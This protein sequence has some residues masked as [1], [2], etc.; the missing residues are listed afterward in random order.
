MSEKKKKNNR[1]RF[2]ALCSVRAGK[3]QGHLETYSSKGQMH[4]FC[5]NVTMCEGQGENSSL[6]ETHNGKY[7]SSTR[8]LRDRQKNREK[9][10]IPE[11]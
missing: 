9:K 1:V 10:K 8:E 5:L 11:E 3:W 7:E 2:L 6:P 4:N